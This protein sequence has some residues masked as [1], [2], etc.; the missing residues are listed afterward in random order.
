METFMADVPRFLVDGVLTLATHN[1]VHRLTFYALLGTESP[2]AEPCVEIAIPE[3]AMASIMETM[4]KML[5][6][7]QR[8]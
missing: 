6:A 4:S 7:E 3:A 2:Q 8:E 5:S 1:G